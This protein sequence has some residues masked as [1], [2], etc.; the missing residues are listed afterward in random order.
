MIPIP[1]AGVYLGVDGAESTEAEVIITAKE[2]QTLVPLPEGASY[3]GFIFARWS[4]SRS[5]R[6]CAARWRIPG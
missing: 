2:G 6:S 5:G 4:V 1:R 3:L